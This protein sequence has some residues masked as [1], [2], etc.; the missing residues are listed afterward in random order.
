[1]K[2]TS[3]RPLT[4]LGASA[5]STADESIR[6]TEAQDVAVETS[7]DRRKRLLQIGIVAGALVLVLVFISLFRGWAAT[8][9]TI[10]RERLRI[11]TV[12]DG[13]FVRDVSAQ[14]SVV[15]AVS[16]TL[17]AVAPGNISYLVRAGDTV[18][19]GQVL[20]TL[21]SP[22]LENE[23]QREREG[24]GVERV[25]ELL[26]VL[27]DDAGAAAGRAIELDEL[28]VQQRRDLRHRAVK[29]RGEAAAHTAGPVR[30][31]HGFGLPSGSSSS[32]TTYRLSS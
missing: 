19:A 20:A 4:K 14:G 22:T 24:A 18:K 13:P 9:F 6:G 10:P 5:D 26:V 25:R 8:E 23:Y 3:L 15:A 16:P 17:F 1:M 30:D 2:I 29:L 11:V 31:L 12:T 7:P 21:V 28:D 27:G 32:P